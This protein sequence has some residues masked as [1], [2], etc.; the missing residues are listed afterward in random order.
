MHKCYEH[1]VT[2]EAVMPVNGAT[3]VAEGPSV[4]MLSPGSCAWFG[5]PS[6]AAA[7]G[8]GDH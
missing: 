4:M 6:M 1:L 2:T 7:H 8:L 3:G 5:G